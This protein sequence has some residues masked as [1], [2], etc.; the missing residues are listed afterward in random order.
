MNY[1]MQGEP[2]G[3]Y[4][5]YRMKH[6]YNHDI[7]YIMISTTDLLIISGIIITC[8]YVIARSKCSSIDF[9]GVHIIR[10]VEL[11]ERAHEYDIEH[12]I[13]DAPPAVP[14]L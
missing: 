6:K 10:D 11:E 9:C 1:H 14:H 12:N 4:C 5:K 7:L 3:V 13:P 2:V 8:V